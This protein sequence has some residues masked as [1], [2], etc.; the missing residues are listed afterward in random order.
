MIIFIDGA[1]AVGK[2]TLAEK[3]AKWLKCDLIDLPLKQYYI[4]YSNSDDLTPIT[5]IITTAFSSKKNLQIRP[6]SRENLFTCQREEC[7]DKGKRGT[8]PYEKTGI[9][10]IGYGVAVREKAGSIC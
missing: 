8:V 1:D 10:T 7:Y 3:L 5:K 6:K 4:D 9:R 2:S